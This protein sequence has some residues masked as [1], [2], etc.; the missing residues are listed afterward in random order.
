MG[1][2]QGGAEVGGADQQ[3]EASIDDGRSADRRPWRHGVAAEEEACKRERLDGGGAPPDSMSR[4]RPL[5]FPLS[6]LPS[7][8]SIGAAA[9][10]RAR[11]GVYP[12][13]F[14]RPPLPLPSRACA[15]AVS[16]PPL[17]LAASVR[18]LGDDF[19]RE[20]TP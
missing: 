18:R 9:R 2:E 20:A 6:S 13:D 4:R 14:L 8:L 11:A 16:P 15:I 10:G 3:V 5:L 1:S 12:R 19:L 7:S 17:A